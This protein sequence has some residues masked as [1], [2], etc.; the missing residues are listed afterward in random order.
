MKRVR[1]ICVI[2]TMF[3]LL[4]FL[5]SNAFGQTSGGSGSQLTQDELTREL[6]TV[7]ERL[8]KVEEEIKEEEKDIWDKLSSISGLVSGFF[9][10]FIGAI[11][12]YVYN[13]RKTVIEQTLKLIPYLTS[14]NPEERKLALMLSETM[15]DSE[16]TT[17]VAGLVGDRY[18]PEDLE[19]EA[20][21]SGGDDRQVKELQITDLME[22][23]KP[24]VVQI[25]SKDGNFWATGFFITREGD[26]VTAGHVVG[27][28]KD[29][30]IRTKDGIEY[31]ARVEKVMENKD[32]ALLKC[33]DKSIV[34][35]PLAILP[36]NNV[37]VHQK[38]AIIGHSIYSSWQVRKGIVF[39]IDP[40]FTAKVK[41]LDVLSSSR[42]TIIE[43]LGLMSEGG[44]SG[45][46]VLDQVGKAIGLFAYS[47]SNPDISLLI[48]GDDILEAFPELFG[49]KPE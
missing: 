34:S 26:V 37:S 16:L 29:F 28:E 13:K 18:S 40:N 38:V 42:R 9:V 10:A 43:V 4:A 12:T 5:S 15:G 30:K 32:L 35:R 47:R 1:S 24:S 2:V 31:D 22:V 11:A 3:C 49:Q 48:P 14:T 19:K 7:S 25:L 21:E 46:P 41:G 45:A 20:E 8:D 33:I 44:F 36:T 17:K 27:Q 39:R 23:F 6:K